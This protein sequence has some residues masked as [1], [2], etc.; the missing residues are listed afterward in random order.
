V[1]AITTAPSTVDAALGRFDFRAALDALLLIVTEGNRYIESARLWER[2]AGRDR[3]A[4]LRPVVAAVECLSSELE[5]FV[6][7]LAARIAAGSSEP[8]FARLELPEVA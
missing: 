8:V 5:P 7:S 2:P 1:R 6:P 3:A 4:A